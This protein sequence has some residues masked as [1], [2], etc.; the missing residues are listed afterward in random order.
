M[1][2][3]QPNKNLAAPQRRS[4]NKAQAPSAKDDVTLL[5]LDA[6]MLFIVRIYIFR[7]DSFFIA[8]ALSTRSPAARRACSVA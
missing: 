6:C 4:A 8:A 1:G 7:R 3:E 5:T 2:C